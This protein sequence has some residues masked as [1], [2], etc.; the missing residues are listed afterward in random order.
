[1]FLQ[2]LFNGLT[3]GATYSLVAVGFSIVYSVLELVN[4]AHGAF[5]VL[6]GYLVLTFYSI[7]GLPYPLALLL[8][9][10]I[11][12]CLGAVMNRTLLEPIR[13]KTSSGESVMTAT[14]GVSTFMLNLLMV[15]FGSET[16]PF[17]NVLGLDKFYLGPVI[18]KWSQVLIAIMAVII[19][20]VLSIMI[21]K[22]KIGSGM[23]AIAQDPTAAKL[24]GVNTSFVITI[25]FFSG[26]VSA[27]IAGVMIAMYYESIDTTM[28]LAVSVKTFAAAL[29]GGIGSLPGA[30][31]G[32]IVIGVLE[33]FVAGYISS[34]WKDCAAF[35]VLVI[36]LLFRPSG[37]FGYK[38]IKKV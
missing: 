19:I 5:Y 27:A 29:L 25:A 11:T 28:Y 20:I 24:M 32:G 12:G 10:V 14:L 2:Q 33:T 26:I 9:I 13:S 37:L 15:L 18:L 30:A 31:I 38:D 3:I 35:V 21:Y 36:V 4:F 17:P 16:K 7:M 34:D 6:A 1:M 8:S 22:T 23:R